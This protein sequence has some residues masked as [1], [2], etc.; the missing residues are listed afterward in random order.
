MKS[1]EIPDTITNID[2]AF[3][4]CELLTDVEIPSNV[5]QLG[6]CSFN[7]CTS[8]KNIKIPDGVTLLGNFCFSGCIALQSV[9]MPNTIE[10]IE[11]AAFED[12]TNL[13]MINYKGTETQWNSITISYRND[14]L[15]SVTINYNYKE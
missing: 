8:L 5:K 2:N 3:A 12:C 15:N 6:Y 10:S 1:P 4:G 7:D 11:T 9:I 13:N 14:I